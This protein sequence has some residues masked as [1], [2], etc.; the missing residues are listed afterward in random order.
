MNNSETDVSGLGLLFGTA[1]L[2]PDVWRHIMISSILN[3]FGERRW[4][5]AN[6]LCKFAFDSANL[7]SFPL[8]K[9]RLFRMTFAV[10]E[11]TAARVSFVSLVC[12]ATVAG[13]RAS[14][15][16]GVDPKASAI[17]DRPTE[18]FWRPMLLDDAS[19]A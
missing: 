4:N 1:L 10:P 19:N 2:F 14:V 17:S 11:S 6:L 13:L 12:S 8:A 16:D 3:F 5:E 7:G 9:S 18:A 15:A